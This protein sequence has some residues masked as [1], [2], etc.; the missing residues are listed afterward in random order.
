[1]PMRPLDPITAYIAIGANL[2][3]RDKTMHSAVEMLRETNGVLVTRVSNFIENPAVGGPKDSPPFLNGVLQV[4]T[5][6]PPEALLDRLLE[7]EKKLGRVRR[8][9]WEP[10][11]IDLDVVLYGDQIV[12]TDRLTIPHPLMHGRD[13][14]LRPLIEI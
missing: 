8:E 1:M 10:R 11:A 4:E 6:L 3:D 9:K 13:F 5:T 7:M 14:V 12:K 2:G